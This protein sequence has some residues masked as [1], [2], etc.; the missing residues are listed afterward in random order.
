MSD[1]N[2]VQK[3]AHSSDTKDALT[4]RLSRIEGQVRGVSRMISEDLYCNDILHQLRSIDAALAGVKQQLFEAHLKGCV[5]EK[6]L[7]GDEQV[8]DELATTIGKMI[9]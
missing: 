6:I 7:A 9:R 3:S 2:Q 1:S 8:L 5:R 4:K